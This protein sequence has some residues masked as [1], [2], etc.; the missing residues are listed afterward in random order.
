VTRRGRRGTDGAQDE[1]GF[2]LPADDSPE[3]SGDAGGYP[4]RGRRR[5]SPQPPGPPWETGGWEVSPGRAGA[6]D[7]GWQN[8]PSGPL[9]GGVPADPH[10]SGPLPPLPETGGWDSGG[11]PAQGFRGGTGGHPIGDYG[12]GGY[13]AGAY[14]GGTGGHPAGDY[15][16]GGYPA[17]GTGG[18]PVGDYPDGYG[19]PGGSGSYPAG[20]Y[21]TGGYQAADYAGAGFGEPVHQRGYTGHG[22]DGDDDADYPGSGGYRDDPHGPGYSGRDPGND[23]GYPDRGGWYGDVDEQQVWAED[24][25]DSGFLPGLGSDNGRRGRRRDEGRAGGGRTRAARR[26]AKRGRGGM[27]KL[28]PRIFLSLLLL[29]VLAAGGGLYY[30]YRTYLHPPDYSGPG[31]GSVVVHIPAGDTATAIGLL[32]QSKGVVASAR[33]FGNAAKAS[34]QG[35]ALEPGYFRLHKHMQA[36]LAL[37]MLLRPSSRVTFRVLIPEG[38]RLSQI[39]AT[40]G[41]DTGNLAGYQAAI[42]KTAQLGLPAYANGNP[43]GYLFPATYTVQPGTPPLQVLQQMVQRFGQTATAVNLAPIARAHQISEHDVI[44]VAS[45]IQAEGGRLQDYPKIARVIYN[46]LYVAHMQLELDSTVMYALHTYGIVASN[47]QLNVNSPYNTYRHYGL[48]PGPIDSPGQA[49]IQAALHP[50]QGPWLYFVTVNPKTGLTEFTSDPNVF[51]QLKAELQKNL[52]QG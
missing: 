28:M 44:V 20:D 33:A 2:W 11:Y 46:R 51:A 41:K 32:L 6:A 45:L 16:S 4:Q 29:I 48:P 13:P 5:R 34:P 18:Y 1:E 35:N 47:Q 22:F 37:A 15:G 10:P 40:L 3:H 9:P 31:S 7:T 43:E 49:A 24:E 36:S 19:D 12:S 50:A 17:G 38:Y 30:V 42:K 25:P 26:P 14:R 27:R 21:A 8:H 52:G 23:P 39:I